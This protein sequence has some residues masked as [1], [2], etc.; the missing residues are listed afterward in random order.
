MS[1]N[2]S[3]STT[4][5]ITFRFTGWTGWDAFRFEGRAAFPFAMFLWSAL[6]LFFWPTRGAMVKR[7][8]RAQARMYPGLDFATH[9]LLVTMPWGTFRVKDARGAVEP[10]QA[11]AGLGGMM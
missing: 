1:T 9:A 3:T 4:H 8:A 5:V 10:A 6:W 7:V 11:D 2:T